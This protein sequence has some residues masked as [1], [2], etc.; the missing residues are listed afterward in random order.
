MVEVTISGRHVEVTESME[1]RIAEHVEKLPRLDGH[2]QHITVTLAKDAKVENV[3]VI[4]KCHRST[5]VAHAQG[6]DLYATIEEAFEKMERQVTRLHGKIVHEHSREAQ[7]AAEM[8]KKP[9]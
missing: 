5:L 1:N 4:A 6:Y 2:I 3:E 8:T 7:K 9:E